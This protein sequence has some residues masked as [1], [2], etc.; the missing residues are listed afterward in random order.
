MMR[1]GPCVYG[2]AMMHRSG[3]A[4]VGVAYAC[5]A[6]FG[7]YWGAWGASIPALREH[8]SAL[9]TGKEVTPWPQ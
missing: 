4:S 6:V 8:R 7:G 9:T 5:F 3:G 1:T 2:F